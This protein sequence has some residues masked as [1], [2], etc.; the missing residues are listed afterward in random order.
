MLGF[1]II[2][3]L[4]VLWLLGNS[5]STGTSSGSTSSGGSFG[6][7]LKNL[8][9]AIYDFEDPKRNAVATRQNNPGNLRPPGGSSSFWT[10][11]IGVNPLNG[12]AIFATFEDG[13]NALL[14]DLS[15]KASK[16][17]DWNLQNLFNVWLGGGPNTAPPA[18]EG[19]AV[20]YAQYVA[21]RLGVAISTTLGQLKGGA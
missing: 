8:A 1:L 17:P 9:A 16:H 7:S 2:A 21:D 11:Q 14:H 12:I 5:S 19:N 4:V 20:T 3:V 18:A 10:G 13:F 6:D 15:I